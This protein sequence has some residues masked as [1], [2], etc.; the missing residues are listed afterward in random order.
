MI[1]EL[2]MLKSQDIFQ[3]NSPAGARSRR[4]TDQVQAEFRY[5]FYKYDEER[6]AGMEDGPF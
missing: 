4:I 6:N 5:G 3:K 2:L 1:L